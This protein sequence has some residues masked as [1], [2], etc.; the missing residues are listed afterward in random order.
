VYLRLNQQAQVHCRADH[1]AGFSAEMRFY[2][3]RIAAAISEKSRRLP[4]D[5]PVLFL[6]YREVA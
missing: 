3:L 5:W 4:E 6:P 2:I 1:V